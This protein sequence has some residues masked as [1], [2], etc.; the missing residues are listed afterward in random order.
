MSNIAEIVKWREDAKSPDFIDSVDSRA[1]LVTQWLDE[2]EKNTPAPVI[3]MLL[4]GLLADGISVYFSTLLNIGVPEGY[5]AFQKIEGTDFGAT[6]SLWDRLDSSTLRKVCILA[7]GYLIHSAFSKDRKSIEKSLEEKLLL[8][9]CEY[10]PDMMMVG[11][12]VQVSGSDTDRI[13]ILARQIS[14]GRYVIFELKQKDTSGHKQLRSYATSY[15]GARLISVSETPVKN[16]RN[17]IEYMTFSEIF[18]SLGGA[19]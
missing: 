11:S 14:G 9:F 17:D 3:D 12:Q 13:D 10:F 18:D 15:E 4:N 1:K 6:N 2:N 8:N 5:A 16:K 7:Q 19:S